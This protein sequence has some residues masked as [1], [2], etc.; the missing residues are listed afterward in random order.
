MPLLVA[1][2]VDLGLHPLEPKHAHDTKG[3]LISMHGVSKSQQNLA[4]HFDDSI[5]EGMDTAKW[6][7]ANSLV[8][9]GRSETRRRVI[10]DVTQHIQFRQSL[11]DRHALKPPTVWTSGAKLEEYL[12]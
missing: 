2:C 4:A 11:L 10:G 9:E 7:L 5:K 6:E 12:A 1:H 8:R 3:D